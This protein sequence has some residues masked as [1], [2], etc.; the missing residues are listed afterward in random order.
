MMLRLN[1]T[2]HYGKI[3]SKFLNLCDCMYTNRGDIV[4]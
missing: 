2:S 1:P 3:I 4:L